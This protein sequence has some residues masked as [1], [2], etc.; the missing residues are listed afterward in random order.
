MVEEQLRFGIAHKLGDLPA[1]LAVGDADRFDY[2]HDS[3][4]FR[5]DMDGCPA[6]V[7]NEGSCS[8]DF[9]LDGNCTKLGGLALGDALTTVH[10]QINA[11]TSVRGTMISFSSCSF[12]KTNKRPRRPAS[13]E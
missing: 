6:D 11:A 12:A 9:R 8:R 13:Q 1:Q 5:G 10:D 4:P 7:P 2:C 3:I